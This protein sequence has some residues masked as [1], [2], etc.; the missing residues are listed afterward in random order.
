M[1]QRNGAIN[2]LW[3][4]RGGIPEGT[5]RRRAGSA[6]AHRWQGRTR[7]GEAGPGQ[8]AAHVR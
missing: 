8:T 2:V 6:G 3:E 4:D 1:A 7:G 5:G